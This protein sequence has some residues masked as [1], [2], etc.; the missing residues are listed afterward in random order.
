MNPHVYLHKDLAVVLRDLSTADLP[1]IMK[2]VNDK[3]IR[4]YFANNKPVTEVEEH[5]FIER[6]IDSKYDRAYT[7]ETEAGEYIGQVSI[8]KI[9]PVAQTGRLFLVITKAFQGKG[10][11]IA[12]IKAV[13]DIAF[14]HEGLNKLYLIVRYDNE[15]AR[16]LYKKCGFETE[17]VLREEYRANNMFYDMV[18]MA[19]LKKDYTHWW[20]I[21]SQEK[22]T[23]AIRTEWLMKVKN[24]RDGRTR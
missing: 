10:Y 16:Y 15:K 17:G 4:F 20:H 14:N 1:N 12:A 18:R 19:M 24:E 13:Q 5:G 8:N 11:A 22:A 3:D 21:T 23:E 6:L 9:D 7:I 2:W